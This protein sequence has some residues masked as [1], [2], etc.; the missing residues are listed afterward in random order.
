M[1][2]K[3]QLIVL[4]RTFMVLALASSAGICLSACSKAAPKCDS[5]TAVDAVI[6]AVSQ[7]MK[8]DMNIV[9]GAGSGD[10]SEEEWRMMRAGMLITVDSIREQSYDEST[11]T[12][13]C[14]G[15]L[16]IQNSGS[17]DTIPI[18]YIPTKDKTTGEARVQL[19]GYREFKSRGQ[20]A[21]LLPS[22]Y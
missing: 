10:L 1:R 16:I 20:N 21:P 7:E 15:N 6:H 3:A 2:M 17:R 11:D 9:A 22:N 5:S 12:R 4:T 8:K 13:T 14:A 18:I 19:S